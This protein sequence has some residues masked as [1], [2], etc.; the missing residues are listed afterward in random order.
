MVRL[1]TRVIICRQG[2]LHWGGARIV[3]HAELFLFLLSHEGEFSGIVDCLVLKNCSRGKP[4]TPKLT[5]R[6]SGQA[7]QS[8]PL[9]SLKLSMAVYGQKL[10]GRPSR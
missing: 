9:A 8:V 10:D 6:V 5:W 3:L 4:Q 2:R 1:L 7:V